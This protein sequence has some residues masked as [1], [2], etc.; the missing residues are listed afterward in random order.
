[1][2]AAGR[3]PGHEGRRAGRTQAVFLLYQHDV[4]GLELEELVDNAER[5]RGKAIDDFTR[6]LIDGVSVDRVAIDAMISAAAEDWT[7]DRIAPLERNII[8]VAVHELLD[9]PEIP[10]AVS[11]NEA[12]ELTKLYCATEAPAFVNGVL[13]RI[14]RDLP[15][16][17]LSA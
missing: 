17:E 12:V 6:V 13:G 2:T 10:S 9:W 16:A 4:T 8:R 5:E 14:V 1:M 7:A 15:A 3:T 11:I